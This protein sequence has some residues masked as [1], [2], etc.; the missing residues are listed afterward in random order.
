M[1]AVSGGKKIDWCYRVVPDEVGS[2]LSADRMRPRGA[3]EVYASG[4]S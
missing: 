2:A 1:S 4:R 3:S